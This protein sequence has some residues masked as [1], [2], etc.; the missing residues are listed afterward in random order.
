MPD[1]GNIKFGFG[2][3]DITPPLEC[4]LVGYA[5]RVSLGA[6]AVLDRLFATASIVQDGGGV[7]IALVSLDLCVLESP[8][9]D[10]LRQSLAAKFNLPVSS[11]WLCCSHTHSGP[12]AQ[13]AEISRGF[14]ANIPQLGGEDPLPVQLDYGAFLKVRLEQLLMSAFEDLQSVTVHSRELNLELGYNRRV[15]QPD[16]S[17][18]H[19]WNPVEFPDREPQPAADKCVS[20]VEFRSTHSNRQVLWVSAGV[21]PVVLGKGSSV[22]SADWPG[23]MRARLEALNP[24]LRVQFFQGASGEIHP[25]EATQTDPAAVTRVGDAFAYPIHL[26]RR[27]L[28]SLAPGAPVIGQCTEWLSSGG[29][30][31][32]VDLVRLGPLTLVAL[33][34]EWFASASERLRSRCQ[35]P[36]F[37]STMS[38]GWE[39]YWPDADAFAQG[40]YE[41]DIARRCGRSPDDSD[42]IEQIIE[43]FCVGLTS[44]ND[45]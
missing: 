11:V 4:P 2:R 21:H 44:V 6:T 33:P 32:A 36:I 5:Q 15:P 9:A 41:V 25:W 19:C 16:G 7:T 17:V 37:L 42:R 23:A 26:A 27:I 20:L 13:L 43:Q 8:V 31:I 30:T 10:A 12:H 28:Q 1:S 24:G 39:A 40:G 29:R 34:L 38:N 35:A 14:A 45:R 22:I 18:K 3:V